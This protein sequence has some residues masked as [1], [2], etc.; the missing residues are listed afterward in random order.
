MKRILILATLALMLASVPTV[1]AGHGPS[2]P[3]CLDES[4][5]ACVP[6]TDP[7]GLYAWAERELGLGP[8]TCDP[9]PTP[10]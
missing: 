1:A 2:P 7:D 10:I 8:C 3:P 5:E 9:H 6:P 4:P